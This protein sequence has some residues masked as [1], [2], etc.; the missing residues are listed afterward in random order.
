MHERCNQSIQYYKKA[1][2]TS[3]YLKIE[4]NKRKEF[5]KNKTTETGIWGGWEERELSA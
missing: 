4:R 1:L 5:S 3:R 2:K